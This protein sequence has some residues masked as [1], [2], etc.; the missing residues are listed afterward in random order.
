MSVSRLPQSFY[1]SSYNTTTNNN[2]NNNNS[3]NNRNNTE[4]EQTRLNEKKDLQEINNRLGLYVNTV[5]AL[6]I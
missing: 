6:S 2:N 4:N 5:S 3:I 1:N